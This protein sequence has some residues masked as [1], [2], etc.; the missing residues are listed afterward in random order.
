MP[1]C[2]GQPL[3]YLGHEVPDGCDV[4]LR[5]KDSY[6]VADVADAASGSEAHGQVQCLPTDDRRLLGL[7]LCRI[8][9]GEQGEVEGP[10]TY[11]AAVRVQGAACT[12]GTSNPE[13]LRANVEAA[14]RG[15]LP[16]DV[17]A[18]AKRRLAAA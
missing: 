10:A 5:A 7:L 4:G 16:P 2:G 17:Y 12:A 11:V 6:E 14:S 1:C 18:E 8:G 3:A 13:H 15:P 9:G